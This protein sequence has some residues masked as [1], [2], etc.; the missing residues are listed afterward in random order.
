MKYILSFL[1][2]LSINKSFIYAEGA[3]QTVIHTYSVGTV[4]PQTDKTKSKLSARVDQNIFLD[5]GNRA[6]DGMSFHTNNRVSYTTEKNGEIDQFYYEMFYTYFDRK[7][8]KLH[9][10]A[11]RIFNVN[12]FSMNNYDGFNISYN[13]I[14]DLTLGVFAGFIVKDDYVESLDKEQRFNSFDYRNFFIDERGGDIIEGFRANYAS[15]VF[16]TYQLEYQAS[17]NFYRLVEHYV[18]IDADTPL[19]Y[20]IFQFYGYGL[21][22]LE[23]GLPAG[24][25][26]GFNIM[27]LDY[28]YFDLE[29]EYYRPVF[30]SDSFWALFETFSSHE[31]RLKTTGK[32]NSYFYVSLAYGALIFPKPDQKKS[33]GE[34]HTI[35]QEAESMGHSV[36]LS[37]KHYNFYKFGFN[38]LT[39]Y[40]KSPLGDNLKT[41]FEVNR[42]FNYVK[43]ILGGGAIFYQ[44][45]YNDPIFSKKGFFGTLGAERTF[46]KSLNL[47]GYMEFYNNFK[48][49]FDLRGIVS[50][51]Y[52]F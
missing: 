35:T 6:V 12:S 4:D 8:G 28:L 43:I 19:F 27:P 21:F 48:Y 42:D 18:S 26:A 44:A 29:Y 17:Q 30:L 20:N 40:L 41:M 47:N 22:D 31:G 7:D 24:A 10:Q 14:D 39:E 3:L 16:G 9:W 34:Q 33:T 15:K 51:T 38:F 2:L 50:I 25:I 32:I 36:E 5:F 11:G 37:V 46:F 52:N 1:I 49:D 23:A 13:I 45:E